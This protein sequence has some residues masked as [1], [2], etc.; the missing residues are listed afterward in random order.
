LTLL[1]RYSVTNQLICQ[2]RSLRVQEKE[3]MSCMQ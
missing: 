1:P 2:G 3:D